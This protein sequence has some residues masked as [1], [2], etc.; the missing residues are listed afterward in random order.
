M[1]PKRDFEQECFD[2]LTGQHKHYCHDWDGMAID[3]TMPEF[4]ACLCETP[5]YVQGEKRN[6]HNDT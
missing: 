3:E 1:K 2:K 6:K 5:S 4:D